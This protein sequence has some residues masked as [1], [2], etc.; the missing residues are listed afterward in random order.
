MIVVSLYTLCVA[1]LVYSAISFWEQQL[2]FV[3]RVRSY[4][5]VVK[6]LDFTQMQFS[7]FYTGVFA[8]N[9]SGHPG[10]GNEYD[11]G[12]T[13]VHWTASLPAGRPLQDLRSSAPFRSFSPGWQQN[14][15]QFIYTGTIP[16]TPCN[17][18]ATCNAVVSVW[19]TFFRQDQFSNVYVSA[20][21]S[22][23]NLNCK[24]NISETANYSLWQ[25]NPGDIP[26]QMKFA[27]QNSFT[28]LWSES[29]KDMSGYHCQHCHTFSEFPVAEFEY[30]RTLMLTNITTAISAQIFPFTC[31]GEQ[32]L[33]KF[34]VYSLTSSVVGSAIFGARILY[35]LLP[36]TRKCC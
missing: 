12:S 30:A 23:R 33:S 21:F 28:Y 13:Q 15:D 10:F 2:P 3:V 22:A 7:T 36:Y 27:C 32:P 31:L 16:G 14:I 29:P 17:G 20:S 5:D 6:C 9:V 11:Q 25:A 1:T 18:S 34:Q 19:R 24:D 8:V 4:D 26:L 35:S